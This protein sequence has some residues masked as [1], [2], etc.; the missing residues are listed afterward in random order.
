MNPTTNSGQTA[1]IQYQ[2]TQAELL[3]SLRALDLP[4]IPGI[5][6][7]PWGEVEYDEARHQF[8]EAGFELK[9]HGRVWL[10]E[11]TGRPSVEE[12]LQTVLGACAYP[13]QMVAIVHRVLP[14]TPIQNYYYRRDGMTVHHTIPRA[15]HHNFQVEANSD[16]GQASFNGL[17][18]PFSWDFESPSFEISQEIYEQAI[19]LVYSDRKRAQNALSEAG[20]PSDLSQQFVD[21]INEHKIQVHAQWVYKFPPDAEQ[22]IVIIFAGQ[23]ACWLVEKVLERKMMRVKAFKSASLQ[24]LLKSVFSP[25]K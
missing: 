10:D 15:S 18:A 19:K 23:R 17:F 12:P 14:A 1:T 25:F 20:F 3:F 2:L 9:S 4:D 16:M 5:G 13:Q 6:E 11:K 7:K 8:R 24:L 22:N 21:G